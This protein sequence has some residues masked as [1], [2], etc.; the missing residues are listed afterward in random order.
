[1]EVPDNSALKIE[2][3]V[4][5]ND[6][7]SIDSKVADQPGGDVDQLGKCV[8]KCEDISSEMLDG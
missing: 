2:D 3:P 7:E 6:E 5:T 4:E 8:D 1:V